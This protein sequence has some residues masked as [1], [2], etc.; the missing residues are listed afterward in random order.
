MILTKKYLTFLFVEITVHSVFQLRSFYFWKYFST[1]ITF[2][3]PLCF[4]FSPFLFIFP[5]FFVRK[6]VINQ[7]F[8]NNWR[9][10]R[11]R[12]EIHKN[13]T[14]LGEICIC[15]I[16]TNL[17]RHLIYFVSTKIEAATVRFNDTFDENSSI[18]PRNTSRHRKAL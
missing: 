15:F 18:R 1:F 3:L 10:D 8:Y 17:P 7:W 11:S 2:S 14:Y 16:R 9:R 5:Y 6:T 4:V 13:I 12:I